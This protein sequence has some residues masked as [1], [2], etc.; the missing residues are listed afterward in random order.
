[1]I[2]LALVFN[3]YGVR[4]FTLLNTATAIVGVTTLLS[5]CYLPQ[6]IPRCSSPRD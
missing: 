5:V 6:V 1:V 4:L 3:L 2:G